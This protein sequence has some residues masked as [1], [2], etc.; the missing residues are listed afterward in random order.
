MENESS[1]SQYMAHLQNYNKNNGAVI[2]S[3]DVKNDK[4]VLLA[5]KGERLNDK[6]AELLVRHKLS[7]TLDSCIGV[8][9]ALNA[10][11]LKILYDSI[12]SQYPDIEKVIAFS[13]AKQTLSPCLINLE[14]YGILYHK[15][16]I[17][18]QVLTDCFNKSLINSSLALALALYS[19]QSK[20][21]CLKIFFISLLENIGYLHLDHQLTQHRVLPFDL[22]YADH[23]HPLVAQELLK[24]IS[25]FPASVT[26]SIAQHQ[27]RVD[28]TGYPTMSGGDQISKFVHYSGIIDELTRLKFAQE[29]PTILSLQELMTMLLFRRQQF[30]DQLFANLQKLII[31]SGIAVETTLHQQELPSFGRLQIFYYSK[32]IIYCDV[33]ARI[34]DSVAVTQPTDSKYFKRLARLSKNFINTV[35]ASG[36]LSLP[37]RRLIEEC[38]NTKDMELAPALIDIHYSHQGILDQIK[39]I[40]HLLEYTVDFAPLDD[41]I[42]KSDTFASLQAC[43]ALLK[44]IQSLKSQDKGWCLLIEEMYNGQNDLSAILQSMK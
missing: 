24:G 9:N 7:R 31:N 29:Q 4:G 36:M 39:E 19:E 6:N 1:K 12:L 23:A 13:G 26:T 3:S 32:C 40:F 14:K 21:D 44:H 18:S 33:I 41:K 30:P 28:G 38:I 43:L 15:L 2:L 5:A 37:I 22:W 10:Q 20:P 17:L 35:F 42:K 27:E 8:D 16:T 34:A 11:S 25:G